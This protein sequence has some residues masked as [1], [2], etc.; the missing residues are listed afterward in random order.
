ME[1]LDFAYIATI[2]KT[3]INKL[4]NKLEKNWREQNGMQCSV[5]LRKS[6]KMNHRLEEKN[7]KEKRYWS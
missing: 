1:F 5:D 6:P 2:R 7:I 4:N 3:S